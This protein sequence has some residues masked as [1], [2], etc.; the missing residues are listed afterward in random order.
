MGV[1]V[2]G[3]DAADAEGTAGD[4]EAGVAG[5]DTL[6]GSAVDVAHESAAA[7]V[8]HGA[9]G[10]THGD[11][12]GCR[13]VDITLA[14]AEDVAGTGM[15]EGGVVSCGLVDGPVAWVGI[16]GYGVFQRCAHE[17]VAGDVDDGAS[18]VL[19]YHTVVCAFV[20]GGIEDYVVTVLDGVVPVAEGGHLAAAEDGAV[21]AWAVAERVF[22]GDLGVG[23]ATGPDVLVV[24]DVALA[25]A[26]DVAA[27]LVGGQQVG[28]VGGTDDG[29]AAHED[30]DVAVG[31]VD[32][33]AY[34]VDTGECQ[35]AAAVDGALDGA[36][37]HEDVDIAL[38]TAVGV[39]GVE[40]V[41][42]AAEDVAIVGGHAACAEVGTR[43]D[44]GVDVAE[45]VGIGTAAEGGAPDLTA[46]DGDMCLVDVGAQP[47]YLGGIPT[48][49]LAGAVDVGVVA[50]V[51]EG[52]Y[53]AVGDLDV[54]DTAAAAV[55][56]VVLVVAG[57]GVTLHIARGGQVAATIDAVQDVAAI[58]VD[59]GVAI[60]AASLLGGY[61]LDLLARLCDKAG[62]VDVGERLGVTVAAAED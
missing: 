6:L 8:D 62:V 4:A 29:V 49:T 5:D 3:V 13:R 31:G 30:G 10:A 51:V 23:D 56:V 48:L 11:P 46:L 20:G 26:E 61:H 33:V 45:H 17:D 36:A 58:D 32:E 43:G 12:A 1:H 38:D 50:V 42:A 53:L 37:I 7:D 25:G 28:G 35:T 59:V 15:Y 2:D 24:L 44:V 19:V 55:G 40:V 34:G 54:A 16:G 41:T 39:V 14:A 47:V 18:G 52:S 60:D 9:G 22:D 57:H 27:A 21:D